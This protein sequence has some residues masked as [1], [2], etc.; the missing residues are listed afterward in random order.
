VVIFTTDGAAVTL[1][2]HKGVAAL[3]KE[4]IPHLTEHCVAHQEDLD[5]HDAWKTVSLMK[6]TETL[7][8]GHQ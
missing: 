4:E 2:K 3:L 5:T 1:G 8:A 6:D 7:L